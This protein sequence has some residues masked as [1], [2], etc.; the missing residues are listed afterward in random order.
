M[1]SAGTTVARTAAEP[2]R[3][4]PW[5][6]VVG[7]SAY[8]LVALAFIVLAFAAHN[9]PYFPL[10]LQTARAVQGIPAPWFHNVMWAISWAG[11]FPQGPIFIVIVAVGYVVA[12]QRRAALYLAVS[13]VD[14]I[15]ARAEGG[16]E[17]EQHQS[18]GH[19]PEQWVAVRPLR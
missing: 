6:G 3:P 15:P 19:D 14:G 11:F 12:H 18:K 1:S 7:W 4:S 9:V 5:F 10:D 2:A 16:I 17:A 13:G 8:G